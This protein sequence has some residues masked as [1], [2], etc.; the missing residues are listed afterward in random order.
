MVNL[1][2]L[3]GK[4]ILGQTKCVQWPNRISLKN[5]CPGCIFIFL[6]PIT[7]TSHKEH[8][9]LGCVRT[10][11]Q[12]FKVKDWSQICL[13]SS[14]DYRFSPLALCACTM[15][16]KYRYVFY[17]KGQGHDIL[18]FLYPDNVFSHN[19]QILLRLV[20]W[21]QCWII[22]IKRSRWNFALK[23]KGIYMKWYLVNVFEPNKIEFISCMFI[24]TYVGKFTL[25]LTNTFFFPF[26]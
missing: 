6:C 18:K 23:G 15:T 19:D 20:Y 10:S 16:L 12:V 25:W 8:V 26:V 9:S 3:C 21:L 11:S 24:K 14:F 2:K 4:N 1:R 7:C 13:E 5:P 22:S 17:V